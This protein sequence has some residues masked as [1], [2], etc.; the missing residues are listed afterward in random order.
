MALVLV[1]ESG[2]GKTNL[3]CHWAQE[4]LAEQHA[5]FFYNCGGS[6]GPD[7]EREVAQSLYLGDSEQL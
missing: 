4:L 3:L 5:V 2:V 6:I 7:V 1:G